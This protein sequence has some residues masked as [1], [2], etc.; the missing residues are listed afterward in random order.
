MDTFE[1]KEYLANLKRIEEA[2]PNDR[3]LS[4]KA[5]VE[6]LGNTDLRVLEQFGI[7]G[8]ITRESFAMRLTEGGKEG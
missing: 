8:K 2:F 6:Y 4:K 3:L 7:A 5:M 1:S